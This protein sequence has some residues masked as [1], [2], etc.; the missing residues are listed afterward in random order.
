MTLNHLRLNC[1]FDFTE[2][3]EKAKKLGGV[4]DTAESI[5]QKVAS[6]LHELISSEP[7][8]DSWANRY[9]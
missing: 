7:M 8:Q 5:S 4:S 1:T 3:L 2:V 9:L 6:F